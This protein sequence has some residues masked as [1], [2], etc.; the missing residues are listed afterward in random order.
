[1]EIEKILNENN[2]EIIEM[3]TF[4]KIP[5]VFYNVL[6]RSEILSSL[7]LGK[8]KILELI[9][10]KLFLGRILFIACRKKSA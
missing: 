2:L 7:R 3:T 6:G 9:F 4:S 1:V 8:E 10:G 5:D